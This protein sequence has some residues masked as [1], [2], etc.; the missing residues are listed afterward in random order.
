[1]S[2][3]ANYAIGGMLSFGIAA[4]SGEL[5]NQLEVRN[6][7]EL[8]SELSD[9]VG[10][11]ATQECAQIIANH[12]VPKVENVQGQDGSLH[13]I[14]SYPEENINAEIERLSSKTNDHDRWFPLGIAGG[15]LLFGLGS[16]VI[17]MTKEAQKFDEVSSTLS[18][19]VV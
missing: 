2:K 8:A 16:I 5:L 9:C 18:D 14:V 4:V 13:V 6:A 15:V 7:H 11:V 3:F 17:N 1:M 19:V 12:V 10:N